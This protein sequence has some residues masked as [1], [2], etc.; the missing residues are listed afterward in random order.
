VGFLLP[1]VVFCEFFAQ[2]PPT[3]TLL[4]LEGLTIPRRRK[5]AVW[6]KLF[7]PDL[8][9]LVSWIL[10]PFAMIFAGLCVVCD[11][12]I[13]LSMCFAFASPML[14]SGLYE[15]FLDNRIVGFLINKTENFRLTLDM[16]ARLLFVVLVGNLDLE[17][18]ERESDIELA[19]LHC[20]HRDDSARWPNFTG[21]AARNSSSPWIH[22][23]NLVYPLRAYRD[24]ATATPRQWPIHDVLCQIPGCTDLQCREKPI[25]RDQWIQK[26][27][28]RTKTRVSK[29]SY[30]IRVFY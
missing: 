18:E 8:S 15:A 29:C 3:S 14:L 22:V 5:L 10:A 16:R 1:A 4:T 12:V 11:T 9:Q 20:Q 21:N 26:E 30:P 23:E 2:A 6:K 25:Q 24:M 7:V 17:P 19:A 27:I 28:G 13:W